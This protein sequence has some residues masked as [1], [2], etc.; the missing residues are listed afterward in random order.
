IHTRPIKGTRPRGEGMGR[1]LV[2]S[3]K[4]SAEHIMIVDLERN[5]LGKIAEIGSVW[6]PELKVL[7]PF[8]TVYHLTSTVEARVKR[9]CDLVDILRTTFPG[10]SITGAPKIRAME[11]IDEVEP[12]GR[13]IYTGSIGY[14]SFS[15][16]MDLNIVIRT[17]FVLEGR[18]HF[19]VGGG[20][21][22]DSDPE[23]EYQETL[24]KGKA[25]VEA[26]CRMDMSG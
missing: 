12:V 20:I 26:L 25:L 11:I 13:S 23:M 8:P 7:E 1:E 3:E 10:G 4:D 18:V 16:H 6:V 17:I 2:R 15:G 14:L 5:D 22:A 9:G 19:Y 21:V 24:D